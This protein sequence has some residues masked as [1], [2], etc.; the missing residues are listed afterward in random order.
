MLLLTHFYGS[1]GIAAGETSGVTI[2][3]GWIGL[4]LL[5]IWLKIK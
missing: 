3:V 1:M 4:G 5:I 2:P